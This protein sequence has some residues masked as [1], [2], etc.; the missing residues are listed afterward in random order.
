MDGVMDGL[1]TWVGHVKGWLCV[2]ARLDKNRRLIGNSGHSWTGIS[3]S[4]GVFEAFALALSPIVF[5][6]VPL[7]LLWWECPFSASDPF[8]CLPLLYIVHAMK[9]RPNDFLGAAH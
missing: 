4:I 6:S 3:L 8:Y 7:N 1:V 9:L 2:H 5:S